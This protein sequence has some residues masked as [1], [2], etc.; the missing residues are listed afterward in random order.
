MADSNTGIEEGN[1]LA[2]KWNDGSLY[3]LSPATT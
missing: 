3:V 2:D 1:N